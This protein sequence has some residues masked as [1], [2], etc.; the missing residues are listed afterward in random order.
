MFKL[1]KLFLVAFLTSGLFST[2][3][4]AHE[5]VKVISSFSVL[6]D[7]VQ[8][9]GGDKIALTT[10][11]SENG[12]AHTFKPSPKDVR[13]ISKA[14]LI[15]TNGLGF[16]GWLPRL[17]EASHFKG[18]QVIASN[19]INLLEGSHDE[20]ADEKGSD[21]HHGDHKDHDA[22]HDEDKGHD[23]HKDED[24][25]H[26]AHHDEDKG[27]HDG[28]DPHAW[29]SI[30]SIKI[31]ARNIAKGLTD[32]DPQNSGYY[33]TNLKTYLIKL[34]ALDN[35]IAA[36]F[37]RVPATQRKVIVAHNAF[38][39]F[40]RDYAINFY[41]LQG[42]STESEASAA[43]ITG[44]IDQ[45]RDNNIKAIFIGNVTDNRL[46]KQISKDTQ[47]TVAGKLYSDALSGKNE[48]ASTY[49]QMMKYNATTIY[50]AIK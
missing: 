45:I 46:I 26:G 4:I 5:K 24:K 28:I 13:G 49:L 43:D 6:G 41:A 38:A 32:V 8:E 20:H 18:Q 47:V 19:G 30:S 17:I 1:N 27:H 48:Q 16:E 21:D 44:V 2:V 31:Y 14:D 29:H 22:H 10:L 35:D 40:S 39:Y 36:M 7:I 50:N 25:D 23:E 15:V 34:K 12:D 37:N 33:A 9:I 11:V 3:A 42:T